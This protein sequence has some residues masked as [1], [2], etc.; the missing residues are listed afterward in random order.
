MKNH[1]PRLAALLAATLMVLTAL[2]P[3]AHAAVASY[4]LSP[5]NYVLSEQVKIRVDFPTASPRLSLW[6][7][8]AGDTWAKVSGQTAK[9]AD[10]SG[11]YTFSYRVLEEQTVQVRDDSTSRTDST[12]E[13]DLDPT[14]TTGVLDP[15]TNNSTGTSGSAVARFAPARSGQAT[16]LQART[17]ATDM[18]NEMPAAAW[19][20]IASS[21]Q[22]AT[23]KTTFPLSNPMEIEHQYRAITTPSGGAVPTVSNVMLFAATKASKRTGLPTVYLNANEG[24]SVNTRERYFEGTFE[25]ANDSSVAA[26]NK[27]EVLNAKNQDLAGK[28]VKAASKGRGNYSWSF[29]KKSFT[30]KL[31][32][33]HDV[34]GMGYSKKFAL[35]ANHYDKSLLRNSVAGYIGSQLTNLAWTPEQRPVDLYVNGSYRGSYIL[36]ERVAPD[37]SLTAKRIPYDAPSDNTG[38]KGEETG[39]ILEW[40]FRK[41]AD[42]NITAGSRGYVGIKDPEN[43]YDDAGV[44]T[45]LGITTAQASYINSYVDAADKALFSGGNWRDHLDEASAVDY[46]IGMELMKPVDGNMWASVYMFKRPGGKLEFGPL[47]DFDLAAGSANRAGGTVSPTGWYLRNVVST[48]AKQSPETWFNRL[49]KDAGFRSKVRARLRSLADE[50]K[51]SD[52]YLA[53][54]SALVKAS[55]TENFKKWSVTQKLSTSQVVKGSHAAEVSYLRSWLK[56]RITWMVRYY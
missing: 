6:R 44:N 31:D 52:A 42:R 54:Q 8:S 22:D 32:K 43:D 46:Y 35:V 51:T 12:G 24:N 45:G 9:S 19:K 38:L 49:N 37:A 47:W 4:T 55:A 41:G 30:V 10:A 18:T 3:T 15:I 23:G 39:Y 50:L 48:S 1:L 56:T 34:C 2:S 27:C 11:V 26:A 13:I 36:I 14:T 16:Q 5:T 29:S 28:Q 7:K 33:K 17:I 25:V 21:T 53:R 20:T 40:D